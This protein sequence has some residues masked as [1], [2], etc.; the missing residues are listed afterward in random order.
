MPAAPAEEDAA[1]E[2][3]EAGVFYGLLQACEGMHRA[4][5]YK[6]MGH[7]RIRGVTVL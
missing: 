5:L 7:C 1:G 3:A 2:A 6:Y 4:E